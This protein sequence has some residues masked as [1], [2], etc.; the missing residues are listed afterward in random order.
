MPHPI[1]FNSFRFGTTIPTGYDK[2]QAFASYNLIPLVVTNK[3]V[4]VHSL[5][6]GLSLNL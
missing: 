6:V 4:E 5:N 2:L 1:D 3:T